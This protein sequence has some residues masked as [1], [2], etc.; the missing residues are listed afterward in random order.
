MH[1]VQSFETICVCVCMW[2][3]VFVFVCVCVYVCLCVCVCCRISGLLRAPDYMCRH[4]SKWREV[5][6]I[7]PLLD[8]VN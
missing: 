3:C 1:C 6:G 7:E 5:K 2:A 8:D 4:D